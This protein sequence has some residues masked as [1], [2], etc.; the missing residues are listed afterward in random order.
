MLHCN[1]GDS[2]AICRYCIDKLVDAVAADR[3]GIAYI[4]VK[5]LQ[6]NVRSLAINGVEVSNK[7]LLLDLYPLRRE[8]FL[9]SK[10]PSSEITKQ[11][12]AFALDKSG[13]NILEDH[14]L[15]KVH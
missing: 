5:H 13:Q 4:T 12:I 2:I 3:N 15:T 10:V 11:F 8:I 6:E 9:V 7:S 14:G 1:V